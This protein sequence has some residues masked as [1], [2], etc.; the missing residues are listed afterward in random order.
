MFIAA[1][2]TI[3]KIWK[4]LRC[5]PQMTRERKCG[6]YT[7]WRL[8][9]KMKWESCHLWQ[10]GWNWDIFCISGTEKQI[11]HVLTHVEA[12]KIHLIAQRIE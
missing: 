7:Q 3:S 1:G 6:I 2:L 5:H 8:I 9:H 10:H 4:H 11:P 12:Y